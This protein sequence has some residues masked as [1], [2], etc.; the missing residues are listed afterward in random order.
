M[1]D[2]GLLRRDTND[3]ASL[4]QQRRYGLDQK[5]RTLKMQTKHQVE[6]LLLN[7]L[8]GLMR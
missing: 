2:I 3:T 5:E 8:E 1:T 6:V 4:R 7:R